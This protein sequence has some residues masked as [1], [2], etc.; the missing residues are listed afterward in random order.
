MI[1]GINKRMKSDITIDKKQAAIGAIHEFKKPL[2][3]GTLTTVSMFVGLFIVSGVTGQ[4]IASIPFTLIFLLFASLFVS[5]AILPLLASNLLH[6]KNTSEFEIKQQERTRKFEA[7]YKKLIESFVEDKTK[8]N[9]F[10][11]SI[12]SLLVF[13]I[14]LAVNVYAGLIA[15]PLTYFITYRSYRKQDDNNCSVLKRKLIWFPQFILVIVFSVFVSGAILPSTKLVEVIFFEQSDVDYLIV[16]IEEPEG[17]TKEI[18]DIAFR[19]VEEILYSQDEI[20]SFTTNVGSGSEFGNGGAGEKFANA[21]INLDLDRDKVSSEIVSELREKMSVLS[22]LNVT[23]NQPSD[24][25]P[26][27]ATL[28]VK[29]LGDDLNVLTDLINESS[30]IF[31][32]NA[33]VINIQTSTN[34]NS[35]EFVVELDKDKAASLGVSPF[36]VSQVARTALYGTDATSITTLDD[37]IDVVVKLNISNDPFATTDTVNNTTINALTDITIQ[38][39]TG[40]V[41]LSSLVEISLRES[42]SVINHEEGKRVV[43]ISADVIEGANAAEVQASLVKAINESL[44]LSGGVVLS[45]GGGE[46]DDSNK[47]FLEM[48][49]AL[50]IG[51]GLMVCVLTLQFNSYLH[52][53]YVLSILPYSLIGIF[54]GL[55]ITGST[56]SFPSMM[57]FIALSGIVVNNSILLI[58]MMNNKRKENPDKKIRDVV[59]ETATSRLRPILLTTVTTVAGMVPLTYAGDL[60]APLAYSVMFGLVFSVFITLLLI[61]ITYLNKPGEV[62]N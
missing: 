60:W 6:R 50:L 57:G 15:A 27:G 43:S 56:L 36:L 24:G 48:F 19:R 45:T 42:S 38:T 17:T 3:S 10:L 62:K 21:F 28:I 13:S 49:L 47:A 61:P 41:P 12:F 33:D 39:Q 23:V 26:T 1:E 52:M 44:D 40:S 4:F 53:R 29:Y 22:D 11:A 58:D 16:E 5:L 9:K 51:I 54:I 8:Q 30:E 59:I 7:W 14:F 34:N 18:T 35:T 2:I 32:A 37:D 55:A 46:S 20:V 31:R 25:P